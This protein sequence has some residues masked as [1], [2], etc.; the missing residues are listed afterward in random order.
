[1][2]A[3]TYACYF[4]ALT[5]VGVWHGSS[6]NFVVFGLLNGVGVTATKMWE[7]A[8]IR[9]RGRAGLREYLKS[10]RIYAVAWLTTMNFVCLTL[11]FF[12]TDLRGRAK[13]LYRFAFEKPA[14]HSALI[15]TKQDRP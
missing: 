7:Q 4:I 12:P 15:R 1:M 3:I 5:L 11:L 13:F 8:I 6:W 2:K 14:A 9:R 10:R